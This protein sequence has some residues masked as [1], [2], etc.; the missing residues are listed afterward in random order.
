MKA[1]QDVCAHC[2]E[3]KRAECPACG[4]RVPVD[5]GKLRAHDAGTVHAGHMTWGSCPG[6]GRAA[7]TPQEVTP[8]QCSE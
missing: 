8:P 7:P 4:R 6:S 1:T 5:G 3:P 2:G